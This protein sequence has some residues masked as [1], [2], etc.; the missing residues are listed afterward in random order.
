MHRPTR[1]RVVIRCRPYV[2]LTAVKPRRQVAET[3]TPQGVPLTLYERDGSYFLSLGGEMLMD[4][5]SAR[6]EVLLG[7]LAAERL[8]A[9]AE[10]RVLI[11]GL[12]FGFTA[13]KVLDLAGRS[14]TVQVAE[15]IPAVVEW[16]RTFLAD[17]HGAWLEDSRVEVCVADV[18]EVLA[19][20]GEAQYDAILLD[21]DNGPSGMVQKSNAR[22]YDRA[23]I[24]RIAAALRPGGRAAIWSAGDDP[25]FAARLVAAGLDVEVVRAKPHA[26]ARN[27]AHVIFVADKLSPR[28][29]RSP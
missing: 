4:T 14:A 27:P 15:L 20:A 16:N 18:W 12:G 7:E 2:H 1:L 11:G 3:R 8:S 28:G 5:A 9:V 23:G 21:V 17:L 6:S 24:E 13:R 25:R 22:L 26:N 10:P 19:R 29:A